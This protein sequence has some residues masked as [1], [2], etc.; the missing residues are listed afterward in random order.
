MRIAVLA[1]LHACDRWMPLDRIERIVTQA[2]ATHPD[3]IVL[4]GDFLVGHLVGKKPIAADR[5]AQVLSGLQA[6]QGVYASLG[7]HDWADCPEAQQ[8]GYAQSSVEAALAEAGLRVLKNA[9][10]QMPNGG[11]VVGL[12]S[13]IG[14]GSTFRPKPRHDPKKAFASI[15]KGASTILLAHEPDVF[16][17]HASPA[18]LQISGH[19][20]G[21][22]IG[23]L[24]I[25]ATLPSRYGTRLD[26]GHK[27]HIER[28]LIISGGLG[29]GGVPLRLGR[30]SEISLIHLRSKPDGA[31]VANR[32]VTALREG[33]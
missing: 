30:T 1:D 23:A 7:N 18:A 3:I 4:P 13:A 10:A 15:P 8:N 9:A 6:P 24:G 22:Q 20:H 14:H 11:Y 27:Q 16:I 2:N 31:T 25:L 32:Q 21:G 33:V 28:N 29:Y 17:E 12:D 19:T 26:Y 5:I